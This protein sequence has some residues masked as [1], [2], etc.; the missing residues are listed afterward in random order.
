MDSVPE[1]RFTFFNKPK[2][3]FV[4]PCCGHVDGGTALVIGGQSLI[5]TNAASVKFISRDRSVECL[6]EARVQEYVRFRPL[7]PSSLTEL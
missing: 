5:E 1:S 2:L 3:A 6:V 4:Y 7:I